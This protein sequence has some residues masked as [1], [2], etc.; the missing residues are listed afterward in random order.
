MSGDEYKILGV[1][2][3]SYPS[4]NSPAGYQNVQVV[5]C[6]GDIGDYAAYAGE[7]SAQWIA[8]HGDKLTFEEACVHFPGG[9]LKV[10]RYRR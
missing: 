1:S 10:E 7:G 3:R 5:L 4:Q 9:Q 8:A 2:R 6:E